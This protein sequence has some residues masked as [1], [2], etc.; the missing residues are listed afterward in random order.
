MSKTFKYAIVIPSYKPNDVILDIVE[1]LS[2]FFVRI[3]VVDDGSGSE[4]KGIFERLEECREVRVIR[5]AVNQGKGRALKTAFNYLMIAS[6]I[7]VDGAITVDGDGQHDVEDVIR[8]ADAL[9]GTSNMVV[10]GCRGFNDRKIPFRSRFG[11]RV[12]RVIYGWACGLRVSDTQT[13]LRGIP[14]SL[15]SICGKIAGEK[16]DYETNM[17]LS[18]RDK[19]V[20]F[21]EIKI[22][23][24]YEKQNESSHFSP[25][26]DSMLIYAVIIKYSIS[27][28]L[29]S[30]ADWIVFSVLVLCGLPVMPSTYS[31]RFVAGL[32]NYS[33][34][35]RFVFEDKEGGANKLLKYFALVLLSGTISGIT[36]E[37]MSNLIP[38]LSPSIIKIPVEIVLYFFN[39]AIQR[40]FVFKEKE[41]N[42]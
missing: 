7:E 4:Y 41:K 31:A 34:N 3:V 22:K 27:S 11:N 39:F 40:T 13:G 21:K 9:T 28:L 5:H 1:K 35:K 8:I 14:A 30:V 36:V 42:G 19:G 32:L 17:L 38:G 33:M 2:E 20:S 37:Y 25:L 15:F 29:T 10:L 16:Y 26:K 23:T 12:S 24:I 6:D 18:F